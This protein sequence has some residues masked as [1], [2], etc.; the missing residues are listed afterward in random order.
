MDTN[1]KDTC[2]R[3]HC[4]CPRCNQMGHSAQYCPERYPSRDE[5]V[6]PLCHKP[7]HRP[8]VHCERLDRC[9]CCGEQDHRLQDCP[10]NE[11]PEFE[12][13]W[14]TGYD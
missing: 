2:G 14:G 9:P 10:H 4:A 3:P 1:L 11:R 13:C 6:C 5:A 7:A 8:G 12:H